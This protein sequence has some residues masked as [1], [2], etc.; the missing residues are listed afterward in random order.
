[1]ALSPLSSWLLGPIRCL[2]FGIGTA[3]R[4][5]SDR[6]DS[7]ELAIGSKADV[8]IRRN[9]ASWRQAEG[10]ARQIATARQRSLA[11]VSLTPVQ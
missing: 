10:W 2:L 1:M 7:S 4:F 11:G 5:L 9:R 3:T 6:A 8:A